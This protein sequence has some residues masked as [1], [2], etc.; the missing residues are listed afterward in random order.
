[1]DLE[2]KN[3]IESQNEKAEKM[4]WDFKGSLDLHKQKCNSEI[5]KLK[6]CLFIITM[7]I[8]NLKFKRT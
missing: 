4:I 3:Y 2:T 6:I 5:R 1:M 7:I 8:I